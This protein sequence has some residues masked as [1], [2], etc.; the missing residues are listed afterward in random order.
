MQVLNKLLLITLLYITLFQTAVMAK[1]VKMTYYW[2][3]KESDHSGSKNVN[4]RTCSG[5][6]IA[7]VSKS[8]ANAA[9][10]EGTAR[11]NN[12][13]IVNLA[14]SCGSG[15]NCFMELDPKRYPFGLGSRSN[16]LKPFI[17]ISANDLP[18]GSKVMVNQLKGLKMPNGITHN[19]CVR[20]DDK[21]WSFGNNH[22]DLLVGDKKY[23]D[24]ISRNY[25]SK[26]RYVDI[27][28]SSCKLQG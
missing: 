22:I 18:Y 4:L 15:Y 10:M 3:A 24:Q 20:V 8:F 13:K 17:S 16:A 19:G 1:R 12:G 11:L 25:G 2:V 9:R 14:C 27:S 23:Y 6:N 28:I 26:L 7:K 5:K 21:G